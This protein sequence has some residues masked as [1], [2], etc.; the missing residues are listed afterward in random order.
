MVENLSLDGLNFENRKDSGNMNKLKIENFGPVGRAEIELAPLTIFVGHNNSGKSYVSKLIHSILTSI[1]DVKSFSDSA[2]EKLLVNDLNAFS[3]FKE[4]LLD[5]LE[6]KP[7]FFRQ[8]F[9]YD[10][11]KFDKLFCE[12]IEKQHLSLIEKNLKCNFLPSLDLLNNAKSGGPFEI[13]FDDMK[14]LNDAGGLKMTNLNSINQN[15]IK[16]ENKVLFDFKRESGEVLIKLDYLSLSKLFNGYDV[17]PMLLYS[18]LAQAYGE[19]HKKKSFYIPASAQ[20]TTDKFKS[21]LSDELSGLKMTSLI[22]KDMLF[23]YLNTQREVKN[24]NFYRIAS[25]IENEVLNGK[26]YFRFNGVYDDL[27]F[28]DNSTGCEFDFGL[29]SSSVKQLTPLI[30]YLKYELDE[31]DTLIIEEIENHL[32]P[33]NQRILVKYLVNLANSGLNIIL[34]THSD[35]ILE[36]FN[37]SIRLSNIDSG[38][39]TNLEYSKED[40]L[41]HKD[42]NIYNFK[43]NSSSVSKFDINETGFIDEVFGQV[44]E[45][46]YDESREIIHSKVR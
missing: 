30:N 13:S 4:K 38:S 32:H 29:V 31:G 25:K 18:I 35:Y 40:A 10:A 41:S 7:D 39:L 28:V 33:A 34:T 21:I 12:G 1:D 6:S 9:F 20:S 24:E 19:T 14:F 46:M 22:E 17:F 36:Q 15:R 8:P 42:V 5:Y 23:S 2:V 16:L 43:N 44:I 37:N 26:I 45:D 11:K 3:D 27:V